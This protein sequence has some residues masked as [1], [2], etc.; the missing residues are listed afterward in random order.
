LKIKDLE[1]SNKQIS[2]KAEKAEEAKAKAEKDL[3]A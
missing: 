1:E 3:K 2:L